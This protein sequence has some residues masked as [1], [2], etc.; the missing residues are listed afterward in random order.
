M[1][2]K[3]GKLNKIQGDLENPDKFTSQRYRFP[4]QL[5]GIEGKTLKQLNRYLKLI[6]LDLESMYE[7][8]IS[9][10][11]TTIVLETSSIDIVPDG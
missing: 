3:Y 9:S 10:Y 1:T 8:T 7:Q 2:E 5:I 4:E 6:S 11:F